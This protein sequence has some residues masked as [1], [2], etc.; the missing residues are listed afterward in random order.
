MSLINIAGSSSKLQE[1]RTLL[2][3]TGSVIDSRIQYG[4]KRREV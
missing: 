1:K 2:T 4:L 3:A